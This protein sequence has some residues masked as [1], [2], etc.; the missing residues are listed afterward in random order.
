MPCLF[1]AYTSRLPE[2]FASEEMILM[3]EG[4][5]EYDALPS[6]PLDVLAYQLAI[7]SRHDNPTY[8]AAITASTWQEHFGFSL[9]MELLETQLSRMCREVRRSF[10]LLDEGEFYV[11]SPVVAYRA[12]C[13]F[14]QDTLHMRIR[15]ALTRHPWQFWR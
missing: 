6:V 14:I 13:R 8:A 10:R 9:H 7:L 4:L 12:S 3:S 2:Q 5:E 1:L 15:M 11:W